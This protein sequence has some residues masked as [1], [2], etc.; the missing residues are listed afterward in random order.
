MYLWLNFLPNLGKF[1]QIIQILQ[2]GSTANMHKFHD[3]SQQCYNYRELKDK[4]VG[5]ST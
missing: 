1:Y 2:K 3:N 4:V 5:Q